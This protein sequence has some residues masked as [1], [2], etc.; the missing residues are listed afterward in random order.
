[1]LKNISDVSINVKPVK[2]SSKVKWKE[3]KVEIKSSDCIAHKPPFVR[4]ICS[5]LLKAL[6]DVG[7]K[8]PMQLH[9]ASKVSAHYCRQIWQERIGVF[10]EAQLKAIMDALESGNEEYKTMAP[11]SVSEIKKFFERKGK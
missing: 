9:R 10:G 5:E 8:N 2:S 7:Y 11:M 4:V 6:K 1:M 3:M